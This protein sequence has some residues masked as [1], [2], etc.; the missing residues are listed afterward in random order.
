MSQPF[1][2]N[3]SLGKWGRIST[4]FYLASRQNYFADLLRPATFSAYHFM[5]CMAKGF[6]EYKKPKIDGESYGHDWGKIYKEFIKH[7]PNAKYISIPDYMIEE[8]RYLSSKY[9]TGTLIVVPSNF[10]NDID[11]RYLSMLQLVPS[12]QFQWLKEFINYKEE[13][14]PGIFSRDNLYKQKIIDYLNGS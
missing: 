12:I 7:Y 5:E 1:I 10:I 11:K 6:L 13:K 4:E 3:A 8:G 9:P 2:F 14:E